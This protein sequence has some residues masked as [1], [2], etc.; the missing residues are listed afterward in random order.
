MQESIARSC[1]DRVLPL[2]AVLRNG[3][4]HFITPQGV[5]ALIL[6][7]MREVAENYLGTPRQPWPIAGAVVT[8]PAYFTTAQKQA[9]REACKIA[10]LEIR[11]IIN[12]PTA[13]VLLY[14][15]EA[16]KRGQM[17]P[18]TSKL[19]LCGVVSCLHNGIMHAP[20]QL[21]V[22]H[23]VPCGMRHAVAHIHPCTLWPLLCLRSLALARST[24][25][26]YTA[27]RSHSFTRFSL[28]LVP[29][30][31][32]CAGTRETVLIFDLGG[33]TF[34]VTIATL[35]NSKHGAAVTV[36]ASGGNTRLG[37]A[38]FDIALRNEC[39]E[40]ILER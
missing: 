28:C 3:E 12:E 4:F 13:A 24:S 40:T 17:P 26:P 32:L 11:T 20:P 18:G 22:C 27:H 30:C 15:L 29:G 16:V 5:S 2:R 31:Q 9:T 8:V 35:R 10:N 33:G 39:V 38:D 34:D 7:K 25:Q 21:S 14:H 23:T 36:L 37:G 19:V 6:R 1:T